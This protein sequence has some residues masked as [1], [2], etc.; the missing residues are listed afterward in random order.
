MLEGAKAQA[1][2]KVTI[3]GVCHDEEELSGI[4]ACFIPGGDRVTRDYDRLQ[5]RK[6][7]S[8][9]PG[10]PCPDGGVSGGGTAAI[11]PIGQSVESRNQRQGSEM[12]LPSFS[13]DFY[14]EQA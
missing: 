12:A 11:G 5:R 13:M 2:N 9:C 1:L 10:H 14:R 4:R 3:Q 8:R 7:L 6:L